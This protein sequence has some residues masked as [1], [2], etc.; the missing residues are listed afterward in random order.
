[1]LETCGLELPFEIL[2]YFVLVSFMD[3]NK[4]YD[5]PPENQEVDFFIPPPKK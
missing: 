1:M 2:S 5:L 3:Q 4:S